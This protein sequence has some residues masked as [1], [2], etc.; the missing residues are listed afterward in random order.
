VLVE[1][2]ANPPYYSVLERLP[3][4]PDIILI[5]SRWIR[6]RHPSR[7]EHSRSACIGLDI[8]RESSC[9]GSIPKMPL[10]IMM[11]PMVQPMESDSHDEAL[12]L[13]N[14]DVAHNT[15]S[16]T[17]VGPGRRRPQHKDTSKSGRCT[18]LFHG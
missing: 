18:R 16:L 9:L 8:A 1:N 14:C 7:A 10:V 2:I 15:L 6:P 11:F 13:Q 5:M 3:T 12:E 4:F 17:V